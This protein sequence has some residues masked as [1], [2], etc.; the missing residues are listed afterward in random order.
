MTSMAYETF[1]PR[2]RAPIQLGERKMFHGPNGWAPCPV[3]EV[4]IDAW[5]TSVSLA[6][7]GNRWLRTWGVPLIDPTNDGPEGSAAWFA[8]ALYRMQVAAGCCV[9]FRGSRWDAERGV[10]RIGVEFEHEEIVAAAADLLVRSLQQTL[11]EGAIMSS[12]AWSSL[13]DLAY[14]RRLGNTTRLIVDAANCRGIPWLRL[15]QES[16]IQLGQGRWQR[17]IEAATTDRTSSIAARVATSKPLAKQLLAGAGI[18]VPMGHVVTDS[19]AACRAASELGWPVV[20]KPSD[21]DYGN[22]ASIRLTTNEQVATAFE[23]ARKYSDEVLVERFVPGNLYR[24]LVVDGELISAVRRETAYV[25]GDGRRTILELAHDANHD[26]NRS[27]ATNSPFAACA[28][29]GEEIP[30]LAEDGRANSVIP[31]AGETVALCRDV[32]LRFGGQ[33]VERIDEVHAALRRLAVDA[34]HVVG[35]DVAGLDVI[36]EDLTRSPFEQSLAILEIN[37]EPALLLHRPP[38]CSRATPVGAAIVDSLFEPGQTGRVPLAAVL[39]NDMARR[40]AEQIVACWRAQ[41]QVVGLAASDGAWLDGQPLGQ[42]ESDLLHHVRRLWRHP[43]T[44][45]VVVHVRPTDLLAQGVPFTQ[46]DLLLD[47]ESRFEL[48]TGDEEGR[49]LAALRAT[50]RTK[51]DE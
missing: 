33:E 2:A 43:R 46:C 12:E 1:A 18:P 6:Q 51:R 28:T 27:N 19:A 48:A 25:V 21:A 37:P 42:N 11:S 38:F 32:F 36:A 35:L 5:A 8:E 30:P 26:P 41:G 39:G 17:R 29:G 15:D 44:E 16:L 50:T 7:E 24:L 3:M 45:A 20:V 22:G 14:D 10:A 4:R 9:E 34:A 31:S 40:V 13:T 47:P 23:A 49:L